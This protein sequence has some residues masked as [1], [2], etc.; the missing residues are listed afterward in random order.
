M[1]EWQVYAALRICSW[2]SQWIYGQPWNV[3]EKRMAT[4]V[5]TAGVTSSI[6]Y[7]VF[8]SHVYM[9]AISQSARFAP[10]SVQDDI[11]INTS[12]NARSSKVRYYAR[13]IVPGWNGSSYVR[14]EYM[15]V[16]GTCRTHC[17][18]ACVGFLG[19]PIF[20]FT[21]T[22]EIIRRTRYFKSARFFLSGTTRYADR[23]SKNWSECKAPWQSS[24][25]LC[26]C[27]IVALLNWFVWKLYCSWCRYLV[28]VIFWDCES[29]GRT[30]CLT[31]LT[32]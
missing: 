29:Y 4:T 21:Y 13:C 14:V 31:G 12:S 28:R 30:Q 6:W 5:N 11:D 9:K 19:P 7:S 16:H 20:K 3:R 22:S 17:R 10:T 1:R 24:H 32:L 2:W 25:G 26:H 27:R 18:R 23:V 15:L 8:Q